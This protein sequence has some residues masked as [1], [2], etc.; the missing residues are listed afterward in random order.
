MPVAAASFTVHWVDAVGLAIVLLFA[1]LGARRGLWWQGVR[2]LGAVA[3]V[4]AARA[5]APRMAPSV[6]EW[7]GGIEPAVA[8]GLV[9]TLVVAVGLVG[10]ALVGRMGREAIEAAEFTTLDRVGG[11]CAGI[12]TALVLH[13]SLLIG[14]ALVAGE[15]FAERHIH[16]TTSQ[17]VLAGLSRAIPGFVEAHAADRLGD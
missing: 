17:D 12:A 2:L 10:V 16:G 14:M 11:I 6:A 8:E 3:T 9:W 7:F 5:L 4:A 1:F 15:G 13:T